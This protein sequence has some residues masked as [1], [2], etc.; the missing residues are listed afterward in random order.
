MGRPGMQGGPGMGGFGD[1]DQDPF[2]EEDDGDG[3]MG[4]LAMGMD[5]DIP[6][7]STSTDRR[8]A[9][10]QRGSRCGMFTSCLITQLAK[11]LTIVHQEV[12]RL[13][14]V[15]WVCLYLCCLLPCC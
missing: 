5:V 8:E 6:T 7:A 13:Y 9:E 12:V 14:V 1:G 3:G 10:R 4:S 15:T 11:L 2:R